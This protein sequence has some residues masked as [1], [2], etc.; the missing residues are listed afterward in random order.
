[1][2]A[3]ARATPFFREGASQIQTMSESI[4]ARSTPWKTVVL[5]CGKCARKMKGGYGVK[6]KDSLRS[7]LRD[8]MKQKGH[9]RDVRIIETRC[10]GLCP[11]KATTVLNARGPES[12]L[13]IPAGTGMDAVMAALNLETD[14][15]E[16]SV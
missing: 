16:R 12:I 5:I 11:K 10:M 13:T 1:M 7:A 6:G 14:T 4:H 8:T 9:G 2:I 15:K 3:T